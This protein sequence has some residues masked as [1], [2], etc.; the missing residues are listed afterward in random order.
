MAEAVS[1]TLLVHVQASA[2]SLD[3]AQFAASL[4]QTSSHVLNRIKWYCSHAPE[5][6]LRP[7][8]YEIQRKVSIVLQPDWSTFNVDERRTLADACFFNGDTV[9]FT[10][11]T[12]GGTLRLSSIDVSNSFQPP[13]PVNPRYGFAGLLS[14]TVLSAAYHDGYRGGTLGAPW[15]LRDVNRTSVDASAGQVFGPLTL[16]EE[17]QNPRRPKCKVTFKI[18][19]TE[20]AHFKNLLPRLFGGAQF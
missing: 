19:E 15:V 6:H 14:M 5:L 7:R 3:E 2:R 20:T 12:P 8:R 17:K 10:V 13:G 9:T 4:P 1:A 18:V 16:A 11:S